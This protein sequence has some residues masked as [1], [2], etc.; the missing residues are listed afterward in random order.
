MFLFDNGEPEEFLL[1]VINFNMNLAASGTLEGDVK[2]QY[3]R[4]LVQGEALRHFDSLYADVES[5]ETLNVD[6]ITRGLD[7]YF[8]PVDLL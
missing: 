5:I 4:T 8:P 7:Q 1:F 6:Y 2:F 3:L